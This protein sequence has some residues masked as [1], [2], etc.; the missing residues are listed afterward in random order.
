MRNDRIRLVERVAEDWAGL[1]PQERD[2]CIAA[3]QALD[4]DPIAGVP[5]FDPLRGYWS[6]RT[7][8]L[9]LVYRIEVQARFVVVLNVSRVAE[10]AS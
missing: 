7:K 1:S 8:W 3:F 2:L 9:R 4:D 10:V 5:L 6:Y